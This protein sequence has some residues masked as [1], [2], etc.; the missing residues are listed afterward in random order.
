VKGEIT[1]VIGPGEARRDGDEVVAVSAVAALV[2]DG[3]PRRSAVDVVSR[4]TG[5]PRN[6]LYR[7]SL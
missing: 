7:G 3:L 2:A 4:L 1:I 6:R 5:I